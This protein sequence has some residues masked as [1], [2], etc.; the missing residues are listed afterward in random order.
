[1][2]VLKRRDFRLAQ[3]DP[4]GPPGQFVPHPIVYQKDDVKNPV[5]L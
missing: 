4:N 5:I 3:Q 2:F 1:M